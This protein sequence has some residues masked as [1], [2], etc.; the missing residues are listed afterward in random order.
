MS[1]FKAIGKAFID[2]YYNKFDTGPRDGV[3]AL[4]EPVN[5]M[6]NFNNADFAKGAQEIAEKLRSLTFQTIGHTVSTMDI[7][8]TYDNC[9]LIVVTG[10][11]KADN[12]PPMQFTE[13][14]LLRCINNAWLVINNVFRLIL[15]G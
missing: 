7:Q 2:F 13:T 14:F 4:Y 11:L 10:A 8:P 6:M 12:D 1:D 9:I 5:G 15:H 3:A